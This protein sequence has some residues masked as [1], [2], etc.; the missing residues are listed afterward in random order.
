MMYFE[1]MPDQ[2]TLYGQPCDSKYVASIGRIRG[3]YVTNQMIEH[4]Y[5]VWEEDDTGTVK[6]IKNR[7]GETVVDMKEFMWIKLQARI[8]P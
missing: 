7:S 3:Y 6:Y 8:I 2:W 4:S 5:R 1:V